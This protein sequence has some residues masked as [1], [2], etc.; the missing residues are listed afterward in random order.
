MLKKLFAV[1]AVALLFAC[2]ENSSTGPSAVNTNSVAN[3]SSVTPSSSS[4]WNSGGNSYVPTSSAI[5]PSSNSYG[6]VSQT[7]YAAEIGYICEGFDF[8]AVTQARAT[9]GYIA[10]YSICGDRATQT[11]GT[12]CRTAAEVGNWLLSLNITT[13]QIN[14]LDNTI[15][16]YGAAFYWYNATDGYQ[17]Y[18]YVEPCYDGI[19]LLSTEG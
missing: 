10:M 9:E 17:R 3:T 6:S 8:G 2:S 5:L 15:A 19:G 11:T 4:N 18:I 1:V 13:D 14:L 7:L 12:T 16:A